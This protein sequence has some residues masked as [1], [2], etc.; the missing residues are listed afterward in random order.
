[1]QPTTVHINRN[2]KLYGNIQFILHASL[3]AFIT[4]LSMYAFR[5]PFTAATYDGL[6]LWSIDYKILLETN[7]KVLLETNDNALLESSGWENLVAE[8]SQYLAGFFNLRCSSYT[9]SNSAFS[10]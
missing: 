1:M 4:Y 2:D 3:A 6:K 5:K 7:D 9:F 8:V 10:F